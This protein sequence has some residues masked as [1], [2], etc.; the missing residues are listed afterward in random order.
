M[1]AV[2]RPAGRQPWFQGPLLLLFPYLVL[3]VVNWAKNSDLTDVLPGWLPAN[4]LD[5]NRAGIGLI[6]LFLGCFGGWG[7]FRNREQGYRGAAL[8]LLTAATSIVLFVLSVAI[9]LFLALVFVPAHL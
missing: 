6:A 3:V 4:W 1:P 8:V 7:Y 5:W 9:V 2:S